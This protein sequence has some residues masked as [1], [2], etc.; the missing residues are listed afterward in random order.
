MGVRTARVVFLTVLR[1]RLGVHVQH[2]LV[3]VAPLLGVAEQVDESVG[4][5]AVVAGMR[6]DA[7]RRVGHGAP[8]ML[9]RDDVG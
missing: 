3:A 8:D 5:V 9:A 7:L 4:R 1:Q 2:H 6:R